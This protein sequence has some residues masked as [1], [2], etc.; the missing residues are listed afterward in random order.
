MN[1][2]LTQAYVYKVQTALIDTTT[3]DA[4]YIDSS[5]SYKNKPIPIQTHQTSTILYIEPHNRKWSPKD[6]VYTYGSQA[7][8]NNTLGATVVD[9]RTQTIIHIDIKSPKRH[10]INKAELAAIAVA[11]RQKNTKGHLKILT[12][13]SFC[14]N[15]IR[16]YTI[17][18]ASYKHHIHKTSYTSP[19]NYYAL[20]IQR[21]SKHPLV[22][23]NHTRTLNTMN[24]PTRQQ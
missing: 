17:D 1:K 23:S 13:N 20:E 19:I 10:T 5:T 3:L 18:P 21:N 14:I 8:G 6:F 7:K 9:P 24:R 16:N 11:L 15:T 4:T 12:D 2:A 22:K